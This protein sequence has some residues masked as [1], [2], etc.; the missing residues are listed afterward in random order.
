MLSHCVKNFYLK[1]GMSLTLSGLTLVQASMIELIYV[2]RAKLGLTQSSIIDLLY[3]SRK[4]NSLNNT[5]G[6][7]LYDGKDLFIQALE[8][9]ED[10]I[11]ALFEKIKKDRRHSHVALIKKHTI[12][13]KRFPNWNMAF[14]DIGRAINFTTEEL[15]NFS[16]GEFKDVYLKTNPHLIFNLIEEHAEIHSIK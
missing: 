11:E 13:H 1:E 5:T 2:S 7:L 10:M 3:T 14:R 6:V 4:N 9:P 12:H 16:Q 8:G 15:D